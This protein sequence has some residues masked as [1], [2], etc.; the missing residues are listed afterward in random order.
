MKIRDKNENENI[1]TNRYIYP[2]YDGITS[3]CLKTYHLSSF[4]V[5]KNMKFELLGH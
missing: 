5:L 2:C 1:I 3:K 4:P